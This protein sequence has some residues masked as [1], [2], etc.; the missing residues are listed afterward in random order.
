MVVYKAC[1]EFQ[2]V[3]LVQP[4]HRLLRHNKTISLSWLR[5]HSIQSE[6][7]LGGTP[8]LTKLL[9]TLSLTAAH[10]FWPTQV[11]F[12]LIISTLSVFLPL[13]VRIAD[14]V[15]SILNVYI[16]FQLPQVP[17]GVCHCANH[18][19][20]TTVHEQSSISS[21]RITCPYSPLRLVGVCNDRSLEVPA[22]IH[23]TV[24]CP[25]TSDKVETVDLPAIVAHPKTVVHPQ[26]PDH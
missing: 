5:S 4:K 12:N 2:N 9:S 26:T 18:P 7:Y 13:D 15:N 11:M 8:H 24:S 21:T 16:S 3:I 6:T 10:I 23:C 17:F 1:V 20:V 25:D 22:L 14:N 19:H